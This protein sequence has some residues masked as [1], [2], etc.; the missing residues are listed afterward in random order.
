MLWRYIEIRLCVKAQTID[1]ITFKYS[2]DGRNLSVT[3]LPRFGSVSFAIGPNT[4]RQIPFQDN[5]N[6]FGFT[7]IWV[8]SG[9][10]AVYECVCMVCIRC[11]C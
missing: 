4:T 9:K 10:L 6:I 7:S 2:N 5:R 11:V 8:S 3:L 1:D